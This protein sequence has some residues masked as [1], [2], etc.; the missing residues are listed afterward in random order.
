MERDCV[1]P[2]FLLSPLQTLSLFLL[3]RSHPPPP[4]QLFLAMKPEPD[5]SS[6]TFSPEPDG[7]STSFGPAN[8]L[9]TVGLNPQLLL[10]WL[11]WSSLL[12]FQR[13]ATL[14]KSLA[15]PPS[16]LAA[17]SPPPTHSCSTW[18]PVF[19]LLGLTWPWFS[20]CRK[21]PGWM[22]RSGYMSPSQSA[23]SVREGKDWGPILLIPP[24]LLTNSSILPNLT[25]SSSMTSVGFSPI[26]FSLRSASKSRNILG[27]MQTKST[28]LTLPSWLGLKKSPTGILKR[29]IIPGRQGGAF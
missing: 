18:N 3:S 29:I 12:P 5:G 23:N 28:K 15:F 13:Q 2:S 6:T 8:K 4:P 11:L 22:A 14:I 19:L 17:L 25:T 27:C 9:P 16:P 10:Q 26:A 24:P 21:S 7:S 1:C 20:L